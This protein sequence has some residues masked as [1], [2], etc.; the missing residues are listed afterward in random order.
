MRDA[1]YGIRDMRCE[2]RDMGCEMC[3]LRYRIPDAG[4]AIQETIS[5]VV[6]RGRDRFLLSQ[7]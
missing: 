5:R 3:D 2:M 7:G 1:G 6:A 4:F